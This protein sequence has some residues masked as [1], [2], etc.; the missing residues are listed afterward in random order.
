MVPRRGVYA[1]FKLLRGVCAP[2]FHPAFEILSLIGDDDYTR[3]LA[4][5]RSNMGERTA[6]RVLVFSDNTRIHPAAIPKKG[7]QFIAKLPI[8]LRIG[9]SH[10]DEDAR[11]C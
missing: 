1:V 7:L 4:H 8:R 5:N 11:Q 10:A 2:L 9:S 6:G 3:A